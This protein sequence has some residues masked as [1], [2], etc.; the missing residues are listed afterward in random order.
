MGWTS[1]RSPKRSAVSWKTNPPIMLAMPSSQTGRRASRTTSPT[2]NPLAWVLLAAIRW[3]TDDAAVHTLAAT[4]STIALSITVSFRRTTTSSLCTGAV[5]PGTITSACGAPAHP[6]GPEGLHHP[7]RPGSASQYRAGHRPFTPQRI[8]GADRPWPKTRQ[9]PQRPAALSGS[10]RQTSLARPA[11]RLGLVRVF[12][13]PASMIGCITLSS[14]TSALA[15][16]PARMAM[17]C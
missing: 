16:L 9:Q 1:D 15:P 7:T 5:P 2:S 3:H 6:H 17:R 11:V 10:P 8:A 12:M 13:I 4:A 14:A